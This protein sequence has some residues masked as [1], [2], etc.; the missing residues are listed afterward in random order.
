M[1]SRL[2]PLLR[3]LAPLAG[4]GACTQGPRILAGPLVQGR[5]AISSQEIFDR[6]ARYGAK[7]YAPLEVS[8]A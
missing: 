4:Q 6:E 5:R 3:H 2:P 1:V 8:V 7:N